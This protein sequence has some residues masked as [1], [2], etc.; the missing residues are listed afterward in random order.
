MVDARQTGNDDR[1]RQPVT[2]HHGDSYGAWKERGGADER[3]SGW[4][5]VVIGCAIVS[6]IYAI[7]IYLAV[8]LFTSLSMVPTGGSELLALGIIALLGFIPAVSRRR[9]V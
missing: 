9:P 7:P 4:T 8:A 5:G 2:R 1:R 6:L 3:I